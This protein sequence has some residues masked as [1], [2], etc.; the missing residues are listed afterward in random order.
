VDRRGITRRSFLVS[1]VSAGAAAVGAWTWWNYD[2][3]S[4]ST[5]TG[6]GRLFPT[7]LPLG[8]SSGKLLDTQFPDPFAGGQIVGYLPFLGEDSGGPPLI[9]GRTSGPGHDARRIIDTAS[10]LLPTSRVTPANEFFIRT[11]YPDTLLA[12][13]EWKIKISGEVHKPQDIPLSKLGESKPQ[14]PV[15]LEC[16]GNHRSLKFGLLSVADWEGVPI[17]DVFELAQPTPKAKAVLINGFDDDSTL[18]DTGAPYREHSWPT[19]SWI[20]T[21]DQLE[22][23]GAFLATRMNG[24]PLPKDQGAPLR[25]VV[26]GWFGCTEVKWVNEIKFVDNNQPATLQMLEF[27]HRTFQDVQPRLPGE[28]HP[29]GPAHARDYRPATIDQSVLPLRVEQWILGGKIAYRV[30]GIT[31]G[32]PNRTD[33]LKIRFRPQGRNARFEPV[34]FCATKTSNL[35]YGIWVHDWEPKVK[36]PYSIDVQLAAPGA[37]S[38]RLSERD[39]PSSTSIGHLERIVYIPAV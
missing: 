28:I 25:L 33:K 23:A 1:T 3:L 8:L 24:A 4:S 6:R 19:C 36:G 16:S 21:F 9:P 7:D 14:G 15:L 32:G 39:G 22:Q 12:P 2:E 35:A 5:A 18:P 30:V 34:Q 31:W 27:S 17:R 29:R 20:F 38:R 13:E 37:R 26:P 11:K 10:L